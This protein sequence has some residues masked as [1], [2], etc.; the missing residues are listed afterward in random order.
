MPRSKIRPS[1]TENSQ[2]G[3]STRTEYRVDTHAVGL[4]Y[5]P[6]AL[7]GN[8]DQGLGRQLF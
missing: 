1:Q 2:D 3:T 6:I 4:E 5:R 7:D 8:V